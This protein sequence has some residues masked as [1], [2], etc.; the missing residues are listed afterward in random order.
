MTVSNPTGG[1]VE[2][3][4]AASAVLESGIGNTSFPALLTEAASR[5]EEVEKA[6]A[7][8]RADHADTMSCWKSEETRL[9]A[10]WT[11]AEAALPDP[12]GGWREGW[13]L[14]PKEP[15]QEMWAASG[16][17]VV[18]LQAR[19]IGH[20]DKISEAVYRA[21]ISALPAPPGGDGEP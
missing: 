16:D 20:H 8:E 19:G 5:I 13:V 15:T 17:A 2:R 14:V 4:R 21:M 7:A 9:A 12:S 3:L 11:A 1:I 18:A 10:G 6:L